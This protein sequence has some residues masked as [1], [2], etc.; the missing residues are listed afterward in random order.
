MGPEAKR[1]GHGR[2]VAA[3]RPPVAIVLP[4]HGTVAEA[5]SAVDAL[6]AIE[7]LP[8]DELV[9]VDN[10][11]AGA[12]KPREG[13][14]VMPADDERS[15]YY[16]RNVGAQTVTNEWI[17]FVDGDCRPHPDILGRYFD[18]QPADEV[19]A[20]VGE[21]VGA[22]G[23][24]ALVSRYARSRGHLGQLAHWNSSFRPWGITANLLVRRAA[25]ASVGGFQEGVR[26]SGDTEF[27]WRLQDAG[28]R[29]AYRPA[30]VV[31]HHHR[32][33][34]RKLA[35]Q[36]ARY[37]AG[38]GWVLRRYPGSITLRPL[39]Q[40]LARCAAGIVAW[41]LTGRFERAAF[42]ALDAVY[43]TSE[44]AARRLSNVPAPVRVPAAGS[45]AGVAG[46]FPALDDPDG[47]ARVRALDVAAV[48]AVTRPLRVD[49]VAARSLDVAW[50]DDDG[51]L[52]RLGAIL[53]LATHRPLRVLRYVLRGRGDRRPLAEIAPRAR[54]LAALRAARLHPVTAG[55]TRDADALGFVLGLPVER[56]T[57][58]AQVPQSTGVR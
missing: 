40:D 32:E 48:E 15:S 11:G 22:P 29:L 6:L 51:T 38:Q 12:V 56:G 20:V 46:V 55:D 1:D 43:V 44:W 19:G 49:R 2:A 47:T 27:S 28:W 18:E 7:R 53:W 30:A 41:T 8:G 35:R 17:L 21:V 52:R 54:R 4:F 10:S 26:S 58:R 9:V 3:A 5:D 16:A 33:S 57:A 50:A 23:Q 37:G 13:V 36:A 39:V 31:E 25:W 42:K 24:D 45:S 34:V 14:R